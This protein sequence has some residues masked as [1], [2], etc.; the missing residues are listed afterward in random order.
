ML[1]KIIQIDHELFL[2]LNGLHNGFFDFVMYWL[3]NK[4]IWIPMY[5]VFIW[6]LYKKY[7][8]NWWKIFLLLITTIV[9]ADQIAVYLFKNT[10]E[11]LRPSHNPD[12]VGVIHLLNNYKGGQFG[13][14]SNHA[15][16]T[17][18]L[19]GFLSFAF[20]PF[21][22]W[23]PYL[24]FSWA[25]LVGY[26]RIYLGVHYPGDVICGALLGFLISLIGIFLLKKLELD[27]KI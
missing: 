13:F 23:F 25:I 6:M 4:V 12:F 16:N 24:I 22:K 8:K 17:F 11:R 18:A 10:F 1:D 9:L 27:L 5:L 15:T 2:I 26:S 3:S 14:V 20:K 19:A 21:Y 7:P